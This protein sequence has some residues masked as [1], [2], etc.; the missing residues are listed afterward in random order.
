MLLWMENHETLIWSLSALSVFTFL[1]TLVAVPLLI[2][3]V[4]A[5]YFTRRPVKD[6]PAARPMVHLSLVIVK[7][8]FGLVLLLAGLAMLVL[9]GQGLLTIVVAT[10][11]L[12]FPGKRRLE[13]WLIRRRAI[14]RTANWIRA[15]RGRPPL[16]LPE[17]N[18]ESRR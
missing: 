6:W 16:E 17:T 11:L 7:N 10:M 4:P 18:L 2:A 1:A 9:P 14:F 5:D 3:R 12:D 13:G 15:G 8:V